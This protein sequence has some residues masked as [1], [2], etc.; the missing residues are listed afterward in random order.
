MPPA[1]RR[2]DKVRDVILQHFAHC[3]PR[4]PP[5]PKASVG[6]QASVGFLTVSGLLSKI[7]Q[8]V[9]SSDAFR[10]RNR[11]DDDDKIVSVYP[12]TGHLTD[13]AAASIRG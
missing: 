4:T 10:W 2:Q 12:A 1:L 5:G 7:R 8:G 6:Q 11:S 13:T 3:V 9:A